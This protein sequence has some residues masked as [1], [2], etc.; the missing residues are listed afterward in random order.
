MGMGVVGNVKEGVWRR[1]YTSTGSG[2]CQCRLMQW[3]EPIGCGENVT[4]AVG[5]DNVNK[6]RKE[7]QTVRYMSREGK[8]GVC[9]GRWSAECEWFA[10]S[11]ASPA[12]V[13]KLTALADLSRTCAWRRTERITEK[14]VVATR[15]LREK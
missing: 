14:V 15:W 1:L 5:G 12:K 11:A 9:A 4:V 10:V 7:R 8:C 6:R 3:S 13:T 2:M